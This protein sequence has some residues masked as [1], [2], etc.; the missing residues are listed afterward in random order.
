MEPLWEGYLRYYRPAL[1]PAITER[2]GCGLV[3]PASSRMVVAADVRELLGFAT[4][5][6]HRSSWS[7]RP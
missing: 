6:F 7:L 5:L 2:A 4:Y 3:D 1:D